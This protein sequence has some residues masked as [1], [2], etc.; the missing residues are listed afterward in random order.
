MS[1]EFVVAVDGPAGAGKS[2][3]AR[4]LAERLAGFRYLDTGAMY[5]AVTA[6]LLRIDMQDASE[7]QMAQAADGLEVRDERLIVHGT[8]VTDDLRTPEVTADVSRVSAV[9]R[10]RRVVQA[11]QREIPGRLVAEGRDIGSVVFPDAAVKVY[12]DASL[13]E[14]ARRRQRQF[15]RFSQAEYEDQ[16][17]RRDHLDSTREDSPLTRTEDAIWIDTTH[18][19]I[20]EVIASIEALVKER[21]AKGGGSG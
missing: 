15:G 2:T 12:L 4:R 21:L 8:D 13:D 6:Y 19:T 18:L 17:E 10:V 1:P 7:E 11:K 20:E 14:R 16:I 3:V 5:R 9:P